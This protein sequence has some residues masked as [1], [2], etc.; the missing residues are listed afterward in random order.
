MALTNKQ[1]AFV[2]EYLIDFNATQAAL[3]AG[4]SERTAYSIGQENLNKPEIKSEIEQHLNNLSMTAEE[5]VLRMSELARGDLSE[6]FTFVDGVKQPYIDIRKAHENG[7]LYLVKK[8]KRDPDG[9]TEI[10]LHDPKDA[11]KEILKVRG[12]YAPEKHDHTV[13]WEQFVKDNV[14]DT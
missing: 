7:K 14:E 13:T 5:A 4:Y 10:E 9:R 6:I 2:S 3:R 8:F 1:R 11:L 12:A